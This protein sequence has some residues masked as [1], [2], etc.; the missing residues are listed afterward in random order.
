MTAQRSPRRGTRPDLLARSLDILRESQAPTGA[1]LAAP[2]FSQYAYCWL[3]DGSFIAHAMDLAGEH[4]S[5]AAFHRWV[6]HT[7]CR[8]RHKVERLERAGACAPRDGGGF[9]DEEILHTRFTAAGDE[10]A[11]D[12]GNFQLD[13]YGLWLASLARHVET[14]GGDAAA[15][16]DAA[17]LVLRYLALLWDRPCYDCWEEYPAQRH[18]TTWAAVAAGLRAAGTLLGSRE[19][20]DLAGT[21]LERLR[22]EGTRDGVLVKFAGEPGF[23]IPPGSGDGHGAAAG[24]VAGHERAGKPLPAGT[25]DGSGLLVLGPLGPFAAGDPLVARTVAAVGERLVA[26]GGGVH[27]Y[28]H[29]EYYGGG[30]WVLLAGALADVEGRM[31]LRERAGTVLAWVE[32]QADGRGRLPEQ[33]SRDLCHPELLQPWRDRWGPPALPLVWSHAMYVIARTTLG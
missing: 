25:V 22:A 17:G 5:A 7:I 8:H 27:R 15:Y 2:A 33:V 10:L 20:A 24:A 9:G 30:L 16:A 23:E 28:E 31:G 6:A 32:A 29:D 11:E 3:R 1:Y 12:W 14:A 13:G 19:H 26:E 18:S 4:A 21:V